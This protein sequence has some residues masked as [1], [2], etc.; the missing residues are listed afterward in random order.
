M[1]IERCALLCGRVEG[2]PIETIDDHHPRY[3]ERDCERVYSC[4]IL[5]IHVDLS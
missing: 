4:L 2:L 5:Q 1:N 3:A